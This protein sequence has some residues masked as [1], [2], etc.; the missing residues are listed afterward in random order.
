MTS[1]VFEHS[2]KIAKGLM[3]L[4]VMATFDKFLFRFVG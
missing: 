4:T 2:E 1:I 3:L